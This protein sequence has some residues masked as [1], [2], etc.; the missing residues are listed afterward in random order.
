MIMPVSMNK[1]KIVGVILGVSILL[2]LF[3]IGVFI[4][5][6]IKFLKSQQPQRDKW[7]DMYNDARVA[8]QDSLRLDS[9]DVVFVGT[10]MTE[11][12]PAE[13][14][15]GRNR[16]IGGNET[17]HLLKRIQH[18]AKYRP[19]KIFIEIGTGDF[20]TSK[21]P[22]DSVYRN[23][24]EVVS[25]A[26]RVSPTTQVYVQSLIPVSGT[27][28]FYADSVVKLN[29]LLENFGPCYIDLYSAFMRGGR[30]DS[31][32]VYDG[33]HPNYAGYKRWLEVLKP[34]LYEL[35][36]PKAKTLV[37]GTRVGH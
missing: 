17:Y 35:H 10:S 30:Q 5:R 7:F 33:A 28:G 25:I 6:R 36:E 27:Y 16:G 1:I 19:R 31:T 18:I 34:Y 12:F 15:P 2:N 37:A 13:M 4:D 32:L 23:L 24:K 21:R 11:G 29:N 9:T 26:Q 22:V 3:L 14:I 20:A 8:I